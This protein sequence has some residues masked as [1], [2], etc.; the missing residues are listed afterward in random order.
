MDK[1]QIK[2]EIEKR[3]KQ[4]LNPLISSITV[5]EL[6]S[7]INIILSK[8][9]KQDVLD[10]GGG[11]GKTFDNKKNNYYILDLNSHNEKHFIQGDITDPSLE[12][13]KK[14][15]IILTK[16]TFEHILNPWDATNNIINLLKEGGLFIC[17]APFSWRF[18]PSPFDAY[19][20]SH[21]GLKYI[22]EHKG[23]I[24]EISSGYV[25]Y[26]SHVSGFWKNKCDWWPYSN[27]QY[28]DCVCSFYIGIRNE[29]AKFDIKNIKGD[30]SL[31]HEEVPK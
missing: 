19:R 4:T 26:H 3:K 1:E 30:Y 10:I 31:K 16:D 11:R 8:E 29:N 5:P 23:K 9:Q 21:Q 17:I 27:N 13:D 7:F 2:K 12:I 6:Y 24:E 18:H 28:K 25:Y 20:Y 22:F 14:F 15:D